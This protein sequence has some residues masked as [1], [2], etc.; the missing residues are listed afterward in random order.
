M[1][2]KSAGS[3]ELKRPSPRGG[4][5][6]DISFIILLTLGAFA[7]SARIGLAPRPSDGGVAVMFAPWTSAA[8]SL[9]QATAAGGRFVRF[10]GLPFIAVVMPADAGYA[11]R[12]LSDGAWLVMDP[13]LLAACA[14]AFSSERTS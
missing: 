12:M 8:D 3:Y 10:G 6:L 5:L 9:S 4:K 1:P 13:K 2:V 11:G 14:A 7:A